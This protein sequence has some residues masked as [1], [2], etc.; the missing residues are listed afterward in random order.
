[1]QAYLLTQDHINTHTYTH[2]HTDTPSLPLSLLPPLSFSLAPSPAPPPPGSELSAVGYNPQKGQGKA[3]RPVKEQMYACILVHP[4][5]HGHTH[6]YA[7]RQACTHAHAC[8][9]THTH[10]HTLS[11]LPP[12]PLYLTFLTRHK[13]PSYLLTL[14]PG[15]LSPFL[16]EVSAEFVSDFCVYRIWHLISHL[17]WR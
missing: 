6:T 15:P 7:H 17:Q 1:M 4:N 12:A 13:I 8:T 5:S 2:A 3:I 9:Y 16:S 10:T 14:S 11:P